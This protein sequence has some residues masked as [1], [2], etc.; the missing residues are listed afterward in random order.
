MKHIKHNVFE[1]LF[2]FLDISQLYFL[3]TYF[4]NIG[5]MSF[6]GT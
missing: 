3:R 6:Y 2:L 4:F 1:N 5:Y